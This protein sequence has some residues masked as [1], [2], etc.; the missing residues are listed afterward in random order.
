[1]PW[2][3]QVTLVVKNQ[4]AN[5]GY[6]R[7]VG[8]VPQLGRSPRGRLANIFQYSCLENPKD[9]GAWWATMHRV[10]H[11]WTQLKRQSTHTHARLIAL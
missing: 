3:S 11:N 8:L 1:M 9:R 5:A 10:T 7:V 2:A 6:I 4:P